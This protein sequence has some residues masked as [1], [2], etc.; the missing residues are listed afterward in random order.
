MSVSFLRTSNFSLIEVKIRRNPKVSLRQEKRYA[1][2]HRINF[3]WLINKPQ[4]W[5]KSLILEI[6]LKNHVF[7]GQNSGTKLYY[8]FFSK[9]T[10]ALFHY[11]REILPLVG[12]YSKFIIIYFWTNE[13]VWHSNW[14]LAKFW[15]NYS[16][17]NE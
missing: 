13:K 6:F 11:I 4:S 9:F 7:Y 5:A 16:V 14:T 8:F 12:R 10:K 17:Q 3:N 2:L 15:K 1:T